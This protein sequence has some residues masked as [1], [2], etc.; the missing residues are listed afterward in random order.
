MVNVKGDEF[1]NIMVNNHATMAAAKADP[2]NGNTFYFVFDEAG[3]ATIKDFDS[4]KFTYKGVFEKGEAVHYDSVEEAAKALNLPNLAA[5]IEANNGYAMAG[6][7]NAF[8]MAG[9]PYLDTSDGIWLMRV[10]P[11]VYLTTAGLRVDID[12]HLLTA[13]DEIIP[14]L[15]AAGDV[16]GSYEQRETRY[17]NGFD[18]AVSF[19]AK[20]GDNIAAALNAETP[21][22][23]RPGF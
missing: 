1:A 10:E 8:G 19:G 22:L 18:A 6:T 21:T 12:G 5:T 2:A 7:A 14:H 13:D 23:Y 15:W 3:A 9:T 11:V 4:Y 16:I 20:V 17:G